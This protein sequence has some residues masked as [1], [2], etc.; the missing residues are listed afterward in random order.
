MTIEAIGQRPDFSFLPEKLSDKL[1]F[2]ERKKVKVDENGLTSIPKVFAGG[3]IV[4]IN[5]DAVTAIADAKIAA[6]G[7]DKFLSK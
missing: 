6:E 5:L 3:D 1:I 2:T 7:I 4:N